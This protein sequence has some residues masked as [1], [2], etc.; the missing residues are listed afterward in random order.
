MNAS[1]IGSV[2]VKILVLSLLVGMGLT[3]F[4]ITPQ[5]LLASFGGTV[6]R[7]FHIVV[8]MIEWAVPY[9]LVGAVVVIPVWL[10]TVLVKI[11]KGRGGG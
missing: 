1:N 9:V 8:S 5:Q 6:Q 4:D 7:I 10:I 2:I 3:F 11:A